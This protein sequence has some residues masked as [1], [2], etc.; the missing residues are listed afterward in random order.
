MTKDFSGQEKEA[1]FDLISSKFFNHNFGMMSKSDYETLLFHIYIEHLL[2]NSLPF[3]DYI[4]SKDLGITQSKVRTLKC[5][6]EL[7][8]PHEGF[9]W[10]IAF[11]EDVKKADYDD[12]TRSISVP[13][14]DVNVLIELRYYLEKNG[15]FDTRTLNPKLFS[16]KLDFFIKLCEKLSDDD[17]VIDEETEK[18]LKAL[19]RIDDGQGIIKKIC[20]GAVEDG[21]RDLAINASKELIV[22]VLKL[23]P[24]GGCAVSV[25]DALITVLERG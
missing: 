4:I 13:I 15:M 16:C 21:L 18:K 9:D 8:Y 12:T 2:N 5:K 14:D 17:V 3:D 23:L 11:A 1:A 25:I 19:K 20:S 22:T 24:F 10:Q 6:K 7:Q